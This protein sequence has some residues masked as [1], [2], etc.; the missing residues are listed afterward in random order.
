[1]LK[2]V[3]CSLG[4]TLDVV[5]HRFVS[6]IELENIEMDTGYITSSLPNDCK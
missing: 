5:L 2:N 1:M 4:L 6:E 3:L